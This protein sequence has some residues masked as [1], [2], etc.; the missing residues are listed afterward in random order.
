MNP[1]TPRL[2]PASRDATLLS[3][4]P[5]L[6]ASSDP[7]IND[8][9]RAMVLEADVLAALARGRALMRWRG[10]GSESTVS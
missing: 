1:L 5:W 3:A 8:R 4:M 2:D 9:R 10:L 7:Q 6:P